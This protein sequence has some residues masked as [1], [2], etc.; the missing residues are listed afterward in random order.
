MLAKYFQSRINCDRRI[1]VSIFVDVNTF[2]GD[3]LSRSNKGGAF[4]KMF[5]L[6][7]LGTVLAM[8]SFDSRSTLSRSQ[9]RE[10]Y[11]AF[12]VQGHAT[13]GQDADSG[14]GVR[15]AGRESFA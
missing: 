9:A 1:R 3:V 2:C 5:G 8:T 4:L 6:C 14:L 10:V 13:G 15:R 11:D 7:L 12:A